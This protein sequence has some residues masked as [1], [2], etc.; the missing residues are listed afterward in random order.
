MEVLTSGCDP[1]VC[2]PHLCGQSCHLLP[3]E[4]GGQAKEVASGFGMAQILRS[5]PD[6][7][8]CWFSEGNWRG[9]GGSALL[10]FI[11]VIPIFEVI[12]LTSKYFF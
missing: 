7:E 2:P 10:S 5:P 12:F 4:T 11:F 8:S 3:G 6:S 9:L 1:S